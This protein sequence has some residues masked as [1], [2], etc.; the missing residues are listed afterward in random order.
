MSFITHFAFSLMML[1]ALTAT[2]WGH[3]RQPE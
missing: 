1:L 3:V 2:V